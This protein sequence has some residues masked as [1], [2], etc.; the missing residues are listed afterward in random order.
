[1]RLAL[2]SPQIDPFLIQ[3]C[4]LYLAQA[5]MQQ[6]NLDTSWTIIQAV[7]DQNEPFKAEKATSKKLV[8]MCLGLMARL[9]HN[10][11]VQDGAVTTTVEMTE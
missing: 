10:Y 6:G 4:W 2:A 7:R 8:N 9:K 11:L 3:R 1:M 5:N